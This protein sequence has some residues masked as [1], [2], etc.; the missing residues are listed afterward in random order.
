MSWINALEDKFGRYAIK[1]L[2]RYILGLQVAGAVLGV[3]NPYLYYNYLSLDVYQ[4]LH[5]QV[6]RL[7]TFVLNPGISRDSLIMSLLMFLIMIYV[8]NWTGTAMEQIL[9]AFRFNLFY[10][11]GTILIWL[12]SLGYYII[13]V[14]ANPGH[15]A[16]SLSLQMA[17]VINLQE[18]C[19]VMFLMFSFAFPDNVVLF[20]FFIPL[21]AKWLGFLYLGM[22]VYEIITCITSRNYLLYVKMFLIIG[23]LITFAIFFL[24]FKK[25]GGAGFSARVRQVRPKKTRKAKKLQKDIQIVKPKGG[26]SRHRCAIC[27][28]T[29]ITHPN[30]EFRYCSQCEGNYEY[31]EE[32]LYTHEHVK[33]QEI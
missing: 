21:K 3:I 22:S 9:G 24:D 12:V 27:G 1:N 20:N 23:A 25:G 28:R 14:H 31:C 17:T 32:H 29:E 2:I 15:L 19:A 16:A 33:K 10:V 13:L 4:I 5:G 30:L 8:Y 11:T 6:W 26:G 7:V 18:L